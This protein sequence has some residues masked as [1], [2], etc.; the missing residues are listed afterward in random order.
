[1]PENA[2]PSDNAAGAFPAMNLMV[3]PQDDAF[4]RQARNS[5]RLASNLADLASNPG[6]M[7]SKFEC[8]ASNPGY[9]TSRFDRLASNP[10]Y[11]ASKLDRL[12]CNPRYLASSVARLAT[13]LALWQANLVTQEPISRPKHNMCLEPTQ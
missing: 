1:M 3:R 12:A 13:Y 4:K 10:G 2:S 8:M 9:L 7:A 6:Y 5:R 11:L